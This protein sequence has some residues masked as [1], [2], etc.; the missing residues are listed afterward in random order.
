VDTTTGKTLAPLRA[1]AR[2]GTI[3]IPTP[4]LATSAAIRLKRMQ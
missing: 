3:T 4:E 1:T 2:G